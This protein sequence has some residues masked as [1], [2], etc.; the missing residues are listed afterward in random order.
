MSERKNAIV[1]EKEIKLAIARIEHGRTKSKVRCLSISAVAREAGISAALIHNH[2]PEIAEL[3]R[4]KTG[5]NSRKQRDA[6][7]EQL[8]EERKKNAALRQE[9]KQIQAQVTRLVTINEM[10][11]CE[12]QELKA[13]HKGGNVYDINSQLPHGS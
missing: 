1:R 6:K 13:K 12:N 5:A 2:Y 11:R 10:L 8:K 3:I 4:T 7:Q 9:R